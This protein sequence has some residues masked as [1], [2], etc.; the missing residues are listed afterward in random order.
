MSW[1]PHPTNYPVAE[2]EYP[3]TGASERF[4][5]LVPKDPQHYDPIMCLESS[6]H[7]IIKREV[8]TSCRSNLVLICVASSQTTSHPLSRLCLEPSPLKTLQTMWMTTH[9]MVTPHCHLLTLL[10]R[11]LQ[12]FPPHHLTLP[13]P[14]F[15]RSP[16]SPPCSLL[17][18]YPLLHRSAPSPPS[19]HMQD[20]P[21]VIHLLTSTTYGYCVVQSRLRTDPYF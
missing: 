19:P 9:R 15:R 7:A 10:R 2:L 3:N 14:P 18:Q 11:R 17:A 21:I 4:I 12:R 8:D 1:E 5:L 13:A 16:R 6:L 20:P